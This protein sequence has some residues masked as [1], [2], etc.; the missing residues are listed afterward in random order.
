MHLHEWRNANDTLEVTRHNLAE[1]AV[2]AAAARQRAEGLGFEQAL[3]AV[4]AESRRGLEPGSM[5]FA[6]RRPVGLEFLQ[7]VL[8]QMEDNL[9]ELERRSAATYYMLPRALRCRGNPARP[10]ASHLALATARYAAAQ[11]QS[12]DGLEV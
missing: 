10:L 11:G 2:T 8:G 7:V 9:A 1:A 12:P 5:I 4:L 3:S 6:A